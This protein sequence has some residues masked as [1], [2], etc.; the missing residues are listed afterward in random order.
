MLLAQKRTFTGDR[1]QSEC[2]TGEGRRNSL[3][4]LNAS[5]GM[6]HAHLVVVLLVVVISVRGGVGDVDVRLELR[7]RQQRRHDNLHVRQELGAQR[8]ADAG[9]RLQH[10]AARRVVRV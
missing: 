5:K 10:V 4:I 1:T 3:R 8:F 2:H 9:A 7:G 6:L